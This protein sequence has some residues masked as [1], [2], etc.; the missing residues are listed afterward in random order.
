M[1]S[2]SPLLN[3][4]TN[5]FK[6]EK[7]SSRRHRGVGLE[8]ALSAGRAGWGNTWESR[9]VYLPYPVNNE[10]TDRKHPA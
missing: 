7:Q 10:E 8:T 5:A 1:S 3:V 4:A 2:V 6:R 9:S